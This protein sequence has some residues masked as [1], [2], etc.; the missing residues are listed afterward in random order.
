MSIVGGVVASV[1]MLVNALQLANPYC[2]ISS[3]EAGSL[4]EVNLL[5]CKIRLTLPN[6]LYQ[7]YGS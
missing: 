3:N 1:V 6:Y 7:D 4:I 5:S 2:N